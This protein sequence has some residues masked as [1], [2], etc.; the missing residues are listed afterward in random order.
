MDSPPQH[1]TNRGFRNIWPELRQ[2]H[3]VDL[4]RWI[5]ERRH[6]DRP[7]YAS[8]VNTLPVTK[9][10]LELLYNPAGDL[11]ITWLGHASCLIQ[12]GGLNVLT[13]P[14]FGERC[15]PFPFAGPRRVTPL[16]L[17]PEDLPALDF[18][19]ISHNH[20]DHLDITAV[21]WLGNSVT[22][23]APLGMRRWFEKRG[24]SRVL[25]LDWWE[26]VELNGGGS[27]ICLPARHF[28]NRTLFDQNRTLW[29]SWLLEVAGKKILFAGDTG[30]ERHFADIKAEYGPPDL[31]ILP[32]GAYHPEW[33]MLPMHL[34]PE[35]AVQAH[36]DLEAGK[37]LGV[38]WGT[39]ILS[40]EPL[41]EPPRR[42]LDAARA[43]GIPENDVFVLQPG[44]TRSLR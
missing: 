36:L 31:A 8:S 25:E 4:L 17:A 38:H 39:F 27:A 1:H 42:F 16:P 30:Y 23:L 28:S 43:Q 35:Q 37:S 33:F 2:Y 5:R 7:R 44:E 34:S 6:S 11:C 41:D 20:Y 19:L 26:H 3:T 22:W 24:M 10:D 21:R 29:A 9:P 12:L 18:V 14:I 32:I 15:S 40:D 13:D